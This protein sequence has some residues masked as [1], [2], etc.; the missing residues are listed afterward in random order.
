MRRDVFQAIADP[1]RRSILFLLAEDTL[2]PNDLARNFEISRQAVSKH[3]QILVDCGLVKQEP[4]G[5]IILYHLLS[6]KIQEVQVWLERF[7]SLLE[8]KFDKQTAS[9][10]IHDERGSAIPV[11]HSSKLESNISI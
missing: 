3:L 2:T 1:T 5:R 9:N 11:Y 4:R 8:K 10:E 7:Q 6:E